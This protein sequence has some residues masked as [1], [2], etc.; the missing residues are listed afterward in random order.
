[1]KTDRATTATSLHA[2]LT[3]IAALKQALYPFLPFSSQK[4]H[5]LLGREG[6]PEDEGWQLCPPLPGQALPEPSPLFTKLDD[7]I[8]ELETAKLG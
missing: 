1:M 6:D 4:L 3:A 7:S 5:T 2:A 8:I